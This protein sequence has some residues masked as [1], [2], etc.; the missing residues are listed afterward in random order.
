MRAIRAVK[1]LDGVP[2]RWDINELKDLIMNEQRRMRS[3][4]NVYMTRNHHY[5]HMGLWL[6]MTITIVVVMNIIVFLYVDEGAAGADAAEG[7]L[8]YFYMAN[9]S[10]FLATMM[11]EMIVFVWVLIMLAKFTAHRMSGPYIRVVN[12]CNSIRDGNLDQFVRFRG[13]DRLDY[14]ANAMN[15]MIM[16]LRL[17]EEAVPAQMNGPQESVDTEPVEVSQHKADRSSVDI[18][19]ELE[20]EMRNPAYRMPNND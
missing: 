3:W 8:L 13:Y 16:A 7:T 15:E 5:S 4:R 12:V 1:K 9:P 19:S 11:V 10:L 2:V 20:D 18:L 17:K 6:V 14:V